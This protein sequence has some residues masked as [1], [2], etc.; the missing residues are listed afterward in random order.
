MAQPQFRREPITQHPHQMPNM[1]PYH[2]ENRNEASRRP[3][4]LGQ[5]VAG[6]RFEVG[7]QNSGRGLVETSTDSS[8]AVKVFENTKVDKPSFN[9][10]YTILSIGRRALWQD[11]LPFQQTI[12][13][14]LAEP[15]ATTTTTLAISSSKPPH[16]S[17]S[18]LQISPDL[19]KNKISTITEDLHRNPLRLVDNTNPVNKE[20][21]LA[22]D[23]R[24]TINEHIR[25]ST[26]EGL[27]NA[28]YLVEKLHVNRQIVHGLGRE[29]DMHQKLGN[30][31][32]YMSPEALHDRRILGLGFVMVLIVVFML[33]KLAAKI[34]AVK[35]RWENLK[36]RINRAGWKGNIRFGLRSTYW[37][38]RTRSA[39]ERIGGRFD[40]F[41]RGD[42]ES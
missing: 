38:R 15:T 22:A 8:N 5:Q 39:N 41:P 7:K 10:E 16:A 6:G 29:T 25:L 13:S 33:V 23:F 2:P 18:S 37:A 20:Y 1:R 21:T 26:Y 28:A 12:R 34:P 27:G 31:Q 24:N 14:P 36:M 32:S 17:S 9:T 35:N 11:G 30:A 3:C 42:V 40:T 4:H 19:Y